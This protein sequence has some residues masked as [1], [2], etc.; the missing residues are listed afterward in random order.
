MMETV[1]RWLDDEEGFAIWIHGPVGGQVNIDPPSRPHPE[2]RRLP[3]WF[4]SSERQ[5][6][7]FPFIPDPG[8]RSGVG[9]ASSMLPRC[10]YR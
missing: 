9:S 4:G 3:W 8:D 6:K 7:M 1:E 2:N 5:L 10:Y